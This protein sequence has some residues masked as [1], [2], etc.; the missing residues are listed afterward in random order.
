MF[1]VTQNQDNYL[2]LVIYD[3]PSFTVK[4]LTTDGKADCYRIFPQS[5]G[6]LHSAL[7]GG[8]LPPGTYEFPTVGTGQDY[9]AP[10]G[11]DSGDSKFIRFKVQADKLSYL[12]TIEL[13]ASD[14]RR[15]SILAPELAPDMQPVSEL[16]KVEFPELERFVSNPIVGWIPTS[17]PPGLETIQRYAVTNSFGLLDPSETSE[18]GF[19]FGSRA[20]VIREWEPG[21]QQPLIHD[22]H[23]RASLEST[24]VLPNGSWLAGGE[25]SAL[26][27]SSDRGK[28]WKSVRGNLPFGAI[29]SLDA[30]ASGKVYVT[31]LEDSNVRIY[32]GQPDTGQW[33]E[34]ASYST[35]FNH[36]TSIPGV[37][38]HT[39][40]QDGKLITSVP[41]KQ[42][43][44]YDLQSDKSVIR[45][46]PGAIQVFSV[47]ADG[48]L[49]CRCNGFAVNPW[50]S[51]DFGQTWARS[52]SS[53]WMM[54]PAMRNA[55]HGVAWVG[56]MMGKRGMAYT[57]DD[58]QTWHLSTETPDVF[59]QHV[60]YSKDGKQ[61]FATND[62]NVLWE[63]DDDGHSW[64]TVMSISRPA[65]ELAGSTL[66]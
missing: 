53:R 27:M 4:R 64:H 61:A 66:E 9:S 48:A 1:K 38:P 25:G 22:A 52:P 41:S 35:T 62:V 51:H 33:T 40:L 55:H 30:D 42:V 49:H 37:L 50:D 6:M 23:V 44:V 14:K 8:P 26:L 20:G 17:A 24:A 2:G 39:F 3:L 12:G 63:S 45:D 28:S 16:V 34:I 10:C 47:S 46:L 18:G 29:V 56:A 32:S 36:W 11:S 65:G 7:F 21:S 19:I 13:T 31:V 5:K 15:R 54:M 43:A 60:F 58:G 59:P 57:D